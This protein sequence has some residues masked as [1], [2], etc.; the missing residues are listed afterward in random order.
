MPVR[1][2]RAGSGGRFRRQVPEAG[3]GRFRRVPGCAG[4][5]SG[6][7][8]RVPV[9]CGGCSFPKQGSEGSIEFRCGNLDR[10]QPCNC[11]E[12]WLVITL[13]TWA[14]PLHKKMVRVVKHGMRI[15]C[16]WGF[17]QSLFF[18]DCAVYSQFP[19]AGPGFTPSLFMT[20]QVKQTIF[21]AGAGNALQA[22]VASI[23]TRMNANQPLKKH[24]SC[25][26]IKHSWLISPSNIT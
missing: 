24:Q 15:N 13:S 11:F 20:H 9:R 14:K 2:A 6:G 8:R 18:I 21:T 10:D 16:C 25:S 4:V 22:A 26:I 17:H 19:T 1:V 5:G 23:V 7:F 3:S 12:H